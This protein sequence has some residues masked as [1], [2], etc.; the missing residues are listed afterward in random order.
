LLLLDDVLAELDPNRQ[1]QLLEAIQERFQTLVTAT[2]LE[3]FDAHWL[4]T[5]QILNIDAG[6]ISTPQ[7]C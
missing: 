1:H 6:K 2:H 7:S 3:A 5:S 4:Q